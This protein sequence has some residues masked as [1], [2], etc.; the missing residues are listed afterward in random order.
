MK[1]SYILFMCIIHHDSSADHTEYQKES[2][3]WSYFFPHNIPQKSAKFSSCRNYCIAWKV[4]TIKESKL[5]MY[6]MK[7]KQKVTL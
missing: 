3:E 5:Y 7:D 1:F 6:R 2:K 4:F